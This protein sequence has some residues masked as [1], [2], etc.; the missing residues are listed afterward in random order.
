MP[1][2][3]FSLDEFINSKVPIEHI[4]DFQGMISNPDKK[5]CRINERIYQIALME[6]DVIFLEY[7]MASP[8]PA[9]DWVCGVEGRK[10]LTNEDIR[11]LSLLKHNA[12]FEYTRG[13]D[14]FTAKLLVS[15]IHVTRQ[16]G[17]PI[18]TPQYGGLRKFFSRTS[19]GEGL[20]APLK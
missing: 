7:M 15:H 11:A 4:R 10:K 9:S 12:R 13:I 6:L 20:I 2:V 16:E 18:P 5:M 3:S 19:G 17:T 14:G 1:M 8:P